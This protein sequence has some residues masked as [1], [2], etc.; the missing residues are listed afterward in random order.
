V[1]TL[2][3]QAGRAGGER[4]KADAHAWLADRRNRLIRRARRALLIRLLGGGN[5]TA[6]D[7]TDSIGR[8]IPTST[9]DRSAPYR[10]GS[11][12]PGSCGTPASLPSGSWPTATLRWTGSPASRVA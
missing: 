2:D 1:S 3:R 11:P 8:T 7:V 9:L 4:R 6:D 12:S 5:A 10:D